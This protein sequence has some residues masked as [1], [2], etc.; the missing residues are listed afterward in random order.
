M[1]T[2]QTT[3]EFQEDLSKLFIDQFDQVIE[4]DPD[5][6]ENPVDL[7]TYV[8]SPLYQDLPVL[9]PRQRK[10]AVALIGD[11]P[12]KIFRRTN[13]KTTGV[14]LWGKGSGKDYLSAVIISYLAYVLCCLKNP[15][16]YLGVAPG[17]ALDI[18]NV[19][20]SATQANLV[21]FS[22]LKNRITKP[23]FNRFN[24][25]LIEDKVEFPNNV[26]L[27]SRHSENESY[28]GFNIIAWVMDEASAFKDKTKRA[29]AETIYATLKSSATSRFGQQW[30]GLIISYPRAQGDFTIRMYEKSKTEPHLYGDFAATWEVHPQR[31]K[32]DFADDYRTN[33]E[34]ARTK[35]ECLPPATVD[36]F[37]S[38]TN[39]IYEA[40][41]QMEPVAIVDNTTTIRNTPDGEREY[42]ALS[43]E[44][45]KRDFE[46]EYFLHGD[47]GLKSDS[48]VLS[49]GHTVPGEEQ[50]IKQNEEIII[51]PKIH[52]DLI[53]IWQPEQGKPVD[54]LNVKDVILLLSTR[55]NIK[56]VTFDQWNSASTIQELIINGLQAEDMTFSRG[57]QLQ[58]YRNLRALIYNNL[59]KW[60][61]NEALCFELSKLQLINGNK[62]DHPDGGSKDIADS[63][64]GCAWQCAEHQGQ[65]AWIIAS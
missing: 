3:N 41:I 22:K 51:L 11:D 24:P 37:F 10:A 29:N 44:L 21:F 43:V 20:Y 32:E 57:Q 61:L 58:I 33:P 4:G 65:D 26:R 19:A 8:T 52:I 38:L 5:W 49:L 13:G 14:L 50:E 28:E 39:K 40:N 54:V 36:A 42:T 60:P 2:Q 56:M 55:F 62:I 9:S 6:L 17:E 31:K 30:I 18:V 25:H 46:N 35:Y 7:D 34:D 16:R 48:F 59:I 47:P 27:H 12:K 15:Q 63:V 53:L 64:A 1:Q 45:L 23:M